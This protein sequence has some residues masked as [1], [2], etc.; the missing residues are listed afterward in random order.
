MLGR[1]G[2]G[3]T[4]R[5]DRGGGIPG[6]GTLGMALFLVALSV[7]FVGS[8]VAV[9]V[10]RLRAGQWPPVGAP[11]VPRLLWLSTALLVGCSLTVHTAVRA[12]RS[13]DRG[14]L[15]R[16]LGATAVL[17]LAFLVSQS[18]AWLSFYDPASFGDN[19]YAFTFFMLTGLHAAHVLGG[20]GA[21]AAGLFLAWRGKFSWAHYGGVR[22][23]ATYWHFL[24]AVWLVLFGF[25]LASS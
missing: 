22:H 23:I 20:L 11:A 9:I 5:S 14:R 15:L 1:A 19:L 2:G 21:L 24:D 10:V 16:W 18:L 12:I 13:G 8:L 3:R 4:P 17:A 25:L 7:L 6:A